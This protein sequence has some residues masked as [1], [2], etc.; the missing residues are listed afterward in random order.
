MMSYCMMLYDVI[1]VVNCEH[2]QV[3]ENVFKLKYA[4]SR[5]QKGQS[6]LYSKVLLKSTVYVYLHVCVLYICIYMY[7]VL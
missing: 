1:Q 4:K 3:G 2:E 7:I 6:P 5:R